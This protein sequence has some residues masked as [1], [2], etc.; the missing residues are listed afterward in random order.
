MFPH[1][2]HV[3]CDVLE[4]ALPAAELARQLHLVAL[5]AGVRLSILHLLLGSIPHDSFAPH[6]AVQGCGAAA[7]SDS[8]QSEEAQAGALPGSSAVAPA[9]DTLQECPRPGTGAQRTLIRNLIAERR[10]TW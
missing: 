9:Q 2:E 8:S 10:R 1:L 6:A 3:A 7:P 5:Q 4:L